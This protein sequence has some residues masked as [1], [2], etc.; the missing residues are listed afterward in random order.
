M[1]VKYDTFYFKDA[2]SFLIDQS[3]EEILKFIELY[4]SEASAWDI[5][6]QYYPIFINSS[7]YSHIPYQCTT[8]KCE[9]CNAYIF[10][11]IP[12]KNNRKMELFYCIN[13]NHTNDK[14]CKCSRCVEKRNQD[15]LLNKLAFI[16]KWNKYYEQNYSGSYDINSLSVLDLVYLQLIIRLYAVNDEYLSFYKKSKLEKNVYPSGNLNI[17]GDL[18]E[19]ILAFIARKIIIP[20][21]NIKPNTETFE[22]F[23]KGLETMNFELTDWNLNIRIPDANEISSLKN[24]SFY[25]NQKKYTSLE[26]DFLWKEVYDYLIKSYI[27]SLSEMYLDDKIFDFTID[28]FIDDLRDDFSISKTLNICYYSINSTHFN[29]NKYKYSDPKKINT[30]FRNRVVE[31]IE[32]NKNQIHLMKDFNLPSIL[33]PLLIHQFILGEVLKIK[34]EITYSKLNFKDSF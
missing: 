32:K 7:I 20:V 1:C 3:E 18:K 26:C 5:S 13:C 15:V 28:L 17:E 23:K 24:L 4:K 25:L 34:E 10:K 21:K 30:H 33:K 8:S 22:D 19:K 2:K 29:M 16:E 12:R 27:K 31:A 11:K 6:S 9:Y 14:N